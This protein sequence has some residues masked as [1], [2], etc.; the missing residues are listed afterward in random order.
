MYKHLD[1][2][3]QVEK[4]GN[5]SKVCK[6]Y[7]ISRSQ[8]YEYKRRYE[9]QGL[10]GLK[11][12]PPVPK[13][14]P[15]STPGEIVDRILELSELHPTRGCEY[16]ENLLKQEGL[17]CSKPTIQ[18]ILKKNNLGSISERICHLEHKYDE[19]LL[20]LTHEQTLAVEKEDPA[21]RER[22]GRIRRPGELLCQTSMKIKWGKNRGKIYVV[23]V[24]DTFGSLAFARAHEETS[25]VRNVALLH[26]SVFPFYCG[27]SI[28]IDA[29]RT[30]KSAEYSGMEEHEY[31][32]CLRTNGITH[33]INPPVKPT[34][35]GFME[36]FCKTV[37]GEFF[38]PF[39]SNEPEANLEQ[40]QSGLEEWLLHYNRER[41]IPGYGNRGLCPMDIIDAYGK[42]LNCT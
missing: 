40:L 14:H 21:F 42:R 12:R 6:E 17:L 22:M 37:L 10:E 5:I 27:R 31:E 34:V 1:I 4:T 35:N 8:F 3:K 38:V 30:E 2:L 18:K 9:K 36:R 32:A 26:D 19:S 29:I 15:F 16:Y 24:I 23:I 33:I 28:D 20:E 13:N 11:N 41:V 7:G 39:F 25:A